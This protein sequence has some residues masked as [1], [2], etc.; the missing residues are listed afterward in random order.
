V[1]GCRNKALDRGALPCLL[2]CRAYFISKSTRA[3]ICIA[4]PT[5]TRW[6]LQAIFDLSLKLLGNTTFQ[7]VQHFELFTAFR[8]SARDLY[9]VWNGVDDMF[10]CISS[11]LDEVCNYVKACRFAIILRE[12]ASVTVFELILCLIQKYVKRK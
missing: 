1:T 5:L 6:R 9:Q 11:Q 10:V 8:Y 7:A 12:F 3:L 4:K 2:T